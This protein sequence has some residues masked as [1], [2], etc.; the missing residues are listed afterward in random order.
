MIADAELREL[1]TEVLAIPTADILPTPNARKTCALAIW[2][3]QV[4]RLSRNILQ[5]LSMRIAHVIRRGIDGE[6]GK[7][8]K[9]GSASDG[10]K[11]CSFG[12]TLGFPLTPSPLGRPRPFRVPAYYIRACVHKHPRLCPQ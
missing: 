1:L 12:S 6:L 7:E 3:I 11:A 8:G 2:V 5:P 10:L 9:K 4:Q